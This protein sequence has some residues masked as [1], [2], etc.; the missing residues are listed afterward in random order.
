[1]IDAIRLLSLM[2]RRMREDLVLFRHFGAVKVYGCTRN[3]RHAL[4]LLFRSR[5]NCR[6]LESSSC[7]VNLNVS[8]L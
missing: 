3:E 7:W 6:L 4:I 8:S 1:M 2:V 5:W